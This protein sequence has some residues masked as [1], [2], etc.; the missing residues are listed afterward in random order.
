MT[1]RYIQKVLMKPYEGTDYLASL[2]VVHWLN[3]RCELDLDCDVTFF[4]GE[5]G[6]GKST[7]LEAIAVAAG[8]NGEGGSKNYN[9]STRQTVSPLHRNLTLAKAD[10]ER[11]GFF[12]RAE[13]F[14]NAATYAV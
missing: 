12:L 13:G 11:D 8:F 3:E 2:P 4:V 7:L 14:Y 1:R 6:T 9:F 5:N 10:F